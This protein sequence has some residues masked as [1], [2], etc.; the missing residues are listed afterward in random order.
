MEYVSGADKGFEEIE[1]Q[2]IGA[3]ERL[4]FAV[5]RSFSLRSA[6]R[7]DKGTSGRCPGYSVLLLYG[8]G[9]PRKAMGLVTLYQ[10]AGRTAIR[11][12]FTLQ[13]EAGEVPLPD[14]QDLEATFVEILT[15]EGVEICVGA[16]E[17]RCI[18]AGKTADTE[19][20]TNVL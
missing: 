17:E 13:P 19:G 9:E 6:T 18:D 2:T 16:G 3:L 20:S 5:R 8:T 15:M 1:R 12:V 4:G 11:P 10:Q 7:G 14:P